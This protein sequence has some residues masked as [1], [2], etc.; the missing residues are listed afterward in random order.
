MNLDTQ[1]TAL[2]FNRW[3]TNTK[4]GAVTNVP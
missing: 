3:N 2:D 4:L 1:V